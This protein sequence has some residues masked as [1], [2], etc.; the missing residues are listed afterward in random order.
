MTALKKIDLL[1]LT[2]LAISTVVLLLGREP[3]MNLSAFIWVRLLLVIAISAII[4]ADRKKPAPLLTLLRLTYPLIVSGYFYS[5]TVF[6]NKFF[7]SNLDPL[8]ADIE[9]GVFGMQ[10]SLIFS[11]YF[12]NQLFSELMYFGYFSFY[13]LLLSFTLYLFIKRR[14]HFDEGAYKLTASLYLFYLIFCFFPS[15][16]PQFYFTFPDNELPDALF[17]HHVMHFIQSVAEQPTGAFPSSHVGISVII[18][19]LSKKMAPH[20]FKMAW[21][22]VLVLILSTVYIKAHYA[23]DIMGGL[24]IVPFILYLSNILY[25]LPVWGKKM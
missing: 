7:F 9:Y 18:L 22:F 14:D 1:F 20:Y 19:I 3:S 25:R 16:G 17:F 12:S 2:Y 5:E 23:I 15:A 6:Y 21:P 8:L 10:P 4:Y 11:V 13:L 24:M